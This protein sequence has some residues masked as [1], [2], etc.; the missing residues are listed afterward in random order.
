[1]RS[2]SVQLLEQLDMEAEAL[3]CCAGFR[4]AAAASVSQEGG[5][6]LKQTADVSAAAVTEALGSQSNL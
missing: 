2:L 4:V 6:G 1:M 3:R 5:G